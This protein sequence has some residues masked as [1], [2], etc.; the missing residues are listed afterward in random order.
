MVKP[1]QLARESREEKHRLRLW[2]YGFLKQETVLDLYAGEGNLSRLYAPR[3]ERLICVEKDGEV[4]E[5]LKSNLSSFDNISLVNCDNLYFLEDLDEENISFVDFDA[6][7][8]PNLAIMKFFEKYNVD[9]AIMVNATDGVLINL[10]R[11]ATV[12]LEKYYLLNLY[13]K[14]R[15]PRREWDSKRHLNRLLP[16]L[17][18]TF[19]HLLAAKYGFNT[20]F[21]YHAMNRAANVTYYGFIS[22][23]QTITSL[24]ATGKTPIIRFK[25]D[26]SSWIKTVRKQIKFDLKQKGFTFFF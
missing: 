25:K 23:P 18:E 11:L 8:C 26:K 17:Q 7:G 12:D 16:W 4:F 20:H 22:Y 5:E 13:P 19:I 24:W 2:T 1:Y 3:C 9:R 14:G 10:S 15:L 21:V 6:Y